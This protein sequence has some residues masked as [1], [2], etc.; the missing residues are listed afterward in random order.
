MAKIVCVDVHYEGAGARAAAVAFDDWS[1]AVA[2]EE[3]VVVIRPV[4]PYEPGAFYKRELPCV[5]AALAALGSLPQIV[6]VDGHVWLGPG[7]PG[8]GAR[9]LEAEPRL[10]TVIGVAKT[11]FA[12]APATPVRR[13]GSAVPLFVD[14]IG[15]PV[16]APARVAEMHG[17]FRVPSMLRRADR[18][19]RG[20]A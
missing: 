20:A 6:I 19:S 12:G 15:E 9:L 8:L 7:R 4:A 16:D 11:R 2:R 14:E 3:R 18:L 1:S 17:P 10:A 5:L 13:G